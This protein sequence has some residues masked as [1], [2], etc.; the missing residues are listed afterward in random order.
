VAE[1]KQWE[2]IADLGN[3]IVEALQTRSYDDPLRAWMAHYIAELMKKEEKATKTQRT[4]IR[5]ECADMII[6]LWSVRPRFDY[7]D[8]INTINRNL[9]ILVGK[10][11]YRRPVV[12]ISNQEGNEAEDIESKYEKTLSMITE[13]SHKEMRTIFVA[14]TAAIPDKVQIVGL[15]KED[16]TNDKID[17]NNYT[18]LLTIRNRLTN[19]PDLPSLKIIS[20]AKTDSEKQKATVKILREIDK[21]RQELIKSIAQ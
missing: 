11:A 20:E 7:Y 3:K 12:D 8:P 10:D 13:L 4:L 18:E 19:S 17:E 14:L 5:K 6:R 21:K 16:D 15:K 9:E 2:E 1:L